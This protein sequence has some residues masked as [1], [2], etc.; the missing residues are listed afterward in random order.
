M[1]GLMKRAIQDSKRYGNYFF[2]PDTIRF[3]NSRVEAGM[4]PNNTFVTSEDNFD[5]S[6]ILYTARKYDW[7]NHSVETIGEFQQF[8]TLEEA[9]R[10]ARYYEE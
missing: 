10:F 9:V 4:F 3:W 1:N 8:A 5:R 7:D 6:K 2:D